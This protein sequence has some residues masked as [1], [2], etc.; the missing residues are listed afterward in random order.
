MPVPFG[1]F[2]VA[3]CSVPA[4]DRSDRY[5]PPPLVRQRPRAY[6]N[7]AQKENIELPDT[8]PF[9]LEQ[10]VKVSREL[11]VTEEHQVSGGNRSPS[12]TTQGPMGRPIPRALLDCCAYSTIQ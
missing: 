12:L 9:D 10:P 6:R 1:P 8:P 3:L 5:I 4:C 2:P 7:L 11:S